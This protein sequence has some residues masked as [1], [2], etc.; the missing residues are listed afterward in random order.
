MALASVYSKVVISLFVVAPILCGFLC[1]GLRCVLVSYKFYKYLA[2]EGSVCCFSSIV[3]LLSIGHQCSV[4]LPY[5]TVSWSVKG[6][7]G[8]SWSLVAY[9]LPFSLLLMGNFKHTFVERH[10]FW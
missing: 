10:T 7:C 3:F 1:W 5:G 9:L 4:S 2:G 6:E 8:I